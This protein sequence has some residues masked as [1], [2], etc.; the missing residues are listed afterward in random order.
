MKF[1]MRKPSLSRS[2]KARTTGKIKRDLKKSINPFYGKSGVGLINDPKKSIYNKVYNK[3]TY[4][5]LDENPNRKVMDDITD[6]MDFDYYESLSRMSIDDFTEEELDSMSIEE[7]SILYNANRI[8]PK[9]YKAYG[10]AFKILAIIFAIVLGLPGLF[11]G[12]FPL[13]IVAV[14][15]Y[16]VFFKLGITFEKE[17]KKRDKLNK[18]M[19][20]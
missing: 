2:I 3:T 9:G 14:I 1:G 15:C 19:K 13:F 5:I 11:G 6:D 17:G 4:G 10:I 12:L 18:R 7:L 16:F 8:S 20:K